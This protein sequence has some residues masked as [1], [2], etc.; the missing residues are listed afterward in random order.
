[1]PLQMTPVESSNLESFGWDPVANEFHIRFKGG[2]THAY[3]GVP[4]ET[5]RDFA[6]ATSK[7]RF[8]HE[9]IRGKFDNRKL[10]AAPKEGKHDEAVAKA[11]DAGA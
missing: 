5:R 7:G 1:M 9:H 10:E 3:A 8:F 4:E 11:S 6:L 2:V